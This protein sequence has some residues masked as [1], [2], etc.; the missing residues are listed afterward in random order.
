MAGLHLLGARSSRVGPPRQKHLG[1]PGVCYVD[2]GSNP[3]H[4]VDWLRDHGKLFA[5][6]MPQSPLLGSR[7]NNGTHLRGL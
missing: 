3:N 6:S 7:D 1:H 2:Q 5:I 4:A